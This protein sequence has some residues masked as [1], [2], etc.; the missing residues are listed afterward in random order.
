MK[1]LLTGGAGF[2]G[3]W[4]IRAL[5]EAGH[6]VRVFDTHDDRGL[7]RRIVG[8]AADRIEWRVGDI[9]RGEDVFDAA[10]GCD[11]AVHLAGV[12]TPTCQAD[13][14]RGAEINL[15]GT[16]NVFQAAR[17][18]GWK[19]LAYASSAGVFG[20]DDGRTPF[21]ATLYGTYKLACEGAARA[22]WQDSGD[23]PPIA[24]LGLRPLVVYGPGRE[25]GSSAGPSH[26]CRAA[27]L[28]EAYRVSFSGTTGF[29]YVE[30]VARAF[31]AAISAPL[32]GAHV[33]NMV[34]DVVSVEDFLAEI[35]TQRPDARLSVEGPPLPISPDIPNDDLGRV[36]PG[37]AHTSLAQGIARTLAFFARE[38]SR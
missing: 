12:L 19:R 3:A 9:T 2:L 37:V 23:H 17:R 22:Y 16:L 11:T 4:V 1:V 7:V 15:I 26:A 20:P 6:E 5:L 38:A 31:V 8:P 10:S 28:G 18:E 29:V 25:G 35:L 33:L 30:D 34:G 27:A 14:I 24:S 36:L 32:E 21:P 13:P